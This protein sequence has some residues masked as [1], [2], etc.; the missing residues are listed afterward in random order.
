[1]AIASAAL[2]LAAGCAARPVTCQGVGSCGEKAACVAGLCQVDGAA[3]DLARSRRL[4]LDPVDVAFIERG[5]GAPAG[6]L[7]SSV[8]LGCAGRGPAAL[9]MRF[10]LPR[11]AEVLRAFLLVER[12]GDAPSDGAGVGLHAERVVAPWDPGGVSWRDGPALRDVQAPS[13]VLR[14]G[15]PSRLRV[16]VDALVRHP[17]ADEPPDQGVALVADRT[18][19]DGVSIVV[20]PK[21][22]S[23]GFGDP[24]PGPVPGPSGPRLEL[25]VK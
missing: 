8:T 25:Y 13:L 1:M 5:S 20:I 3:S 12:D 19:A 7:A 6:S 14:R 4:V 21:L 11:E 18:S 17:R 24:D 22:T 2:V 15:G 10:N 9:L 16:D 23:A